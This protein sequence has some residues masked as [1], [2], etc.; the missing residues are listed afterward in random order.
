MA[1]DVNKATGATS[2]VDDVMKDTGATSLLE[3]QGHCL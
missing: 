3:E 2:L 1:V